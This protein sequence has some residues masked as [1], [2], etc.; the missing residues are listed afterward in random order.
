MV[1]S[2]E[3]WAA[4]I[5]RANGPHRRLL[6]G[7]PAFADARTKPDALFAIALGR[8]PISVL[9][10]LGGFATHLLDVHM[11]HDRA[12]VGRYFD[13]AETWQRLVD[14]AVVLVLTGINEPDKLLRMLFVRSAA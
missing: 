8:T 12:L 1:V 10:P 11:R 14:R 4:E 2:E 5:S 9:H 3:A 13:R 7:C 6:A